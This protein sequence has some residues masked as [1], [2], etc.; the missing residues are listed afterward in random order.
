MVKYRHELKYLIGKT[1]ALELSQRV[2]AVMPLDPHAG[3]GR[4]YLVR[5]LYLDDAAD[6]AYFEKIDGDERRRKYRFRLY[7]QDPSYI[8]LECKHKDADMTYKESL[9]IPRE[10]LGRLLHEQFQAGVRDAFLQ[11]Y[12]REKVTRGLEPSV[13]VDYRRTAYVYPAGNVRVTFDDDLRAGGQ[14]K[15]LLD[16]SSPTRPVLPAGMLV[17]E[18]K[19]DEYLPEHIRRLFYGVP[20]IRQAVSKFALCRAVL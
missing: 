8:R 3:E 10:L 5:S 9:R 2:K 13:V 19:Y 6:T 4:T 12:L 11:K 1:E 7:N 20:M 16:F 14:G 18:I 15:D 17:V